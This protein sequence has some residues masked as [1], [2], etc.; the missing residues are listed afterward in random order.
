MSDFRT[1]FEIPELPKK[2]EYGSKILLMGSCFSENIG[3]KLSDYKF[4]VNINPFGILYNPESIAQSLEIL[5]KGKEFSEKDLFE[6]EGVWNSFYH[7]S[8]F[9][10]TDP[11]LCLKQ[12]NKSIQEGKRQLEE[13]DFLLITLGTAWVYELKKL[14]K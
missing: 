13:I 12:I 1:T 9:S 10:N 14:V 8:R 5:L 4:D 6:H 3:K 7:H 2:I 11:E